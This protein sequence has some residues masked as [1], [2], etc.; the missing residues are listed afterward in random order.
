MLIISLHGQNYSSENKFGVSNGVRRRLYSLTHRDVRS[1]TIYSSAQFT[2]LSG[3]NCFFHTYSTISDCNFTSCRLFPEQISW[4]RIQLVWVDVSVKSFTRIWKIFIVYLLLLSLV[5]LITFHISSIW[6]SRYVV[7]LKYSSSDNL[8]NCLLYKLTFIDCGKIYSN[9]L[10]ISSFK[11]QSLINISTVSNKSLADTFVLS[12]ADDNKR[13]VTIENL[14]IYF[15]N[16]YLIMDVPT[17]L[18]QMYTS[19]LTNFLTMADYLGER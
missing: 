19:L 16:R 2:R 14:M 18:M 3:T 15:V 5:F 6:L 8:E 12:E 11:V 10:Y 1:S 4:V 13:D 7:D 17:E 9:W